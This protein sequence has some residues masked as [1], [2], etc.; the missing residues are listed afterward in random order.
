MP[1][2]FDLL[3]FMLQGLGVTLVITVGGSMVALVSA[4]LAGLGRRSDDV[5]V[6]WLSGAYIEIFRGAS[7]LVLLYWFFFALP[8]LLDIRVNAILAGIIVLG[9]NVGAYGAEVVRAS[10]AAV[11]EGQ[12]RA[13]KALNLTSW[14]TMRYV[15]VPQA[16]L[17]MIPPFGNLL[18]ELLKGTALV[19]VVTVSD[20]TN[21]GMLLRDQ[22]HRSLEI[23]GILLLVYF[24]LSLIL[25]T[26]VR[27]LERRL[28]RGQDHGKG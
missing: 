7:A 13:A 4:I 24:G 21:R 16:V 15:I 23:F 27:W 19:S 1:P 20:L 2:P 26:G 5:I 11:P 12:Y 3:P 18:I 25:T 22:T 10:I 28:S 17:A 6:R 14:Q 9:L 8:V